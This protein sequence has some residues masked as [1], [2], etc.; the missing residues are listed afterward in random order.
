MLRSGVVDG[1]LLGSVSVGDDAVTHTTHCVSSA[2]RLP[3]FVR[4]CVCCAVHMMMMIKLH[5]IVRG[6]KTSISRNEMTIVFY[7]SFKWC[8]IQ[9][10]RWDPLLSLEVAKVENEET[11]RRLPR[12]VWYASSQKILTECSFSCFHLTNHGA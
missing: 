3:V 5:H 9:I 11:C 1:Y 7:V 4:V 8:E 12:C 2:S 10:G 6:E